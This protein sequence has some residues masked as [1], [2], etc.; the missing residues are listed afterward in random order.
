MFHFPN[1]LLIRYSH[2]LTHKRRPVFF[3]E[4]PQPPRFLLGPFLV[5]CVE[6]SKRSRSRR[7]ESSDSDEVD[8]PVQSMQAAW[9]SS[10]P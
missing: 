10:M 7:S 3:L 5:F 1:N 2:V 9:R 4:A 6:A 8:G